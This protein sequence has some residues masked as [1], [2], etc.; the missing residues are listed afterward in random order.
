MVRYREI[1]KIYKIYNSVYL[2]PL[3]CTLCKLVTDED[4]MY[5][6]L[7]SGIQRSTLYCLTFLSRNKDGEIFL[8]CNPDNMSGLPYK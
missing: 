7:Y 2:Y 3:Q 8:F 5:P 1:I 6:Y 4:D